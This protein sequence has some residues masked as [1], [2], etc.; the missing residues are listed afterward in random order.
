MFTLSNLDH[1]KLQQLRDF[2]SQTGVKVLAFSEVEVHPAR[3]DDDVLVNLKGLEKK[4]G[5]TLVAYK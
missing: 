3:I 5:V 4:L 2:E 1:G